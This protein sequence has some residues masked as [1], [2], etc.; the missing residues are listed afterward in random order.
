MNEKDCARISEKSN[1]LHILKQK[2]EKSDFR[3]LIK[4]KKGRVKW[5]PEFSVG[6]HL[7]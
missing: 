5:I 1:F 3:F 2:L 4:N 7:N 6:M